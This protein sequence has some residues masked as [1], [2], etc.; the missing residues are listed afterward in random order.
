MNEIEER[1]EIVI[2][3]Q[4]VRLGWPDKVKMEAIN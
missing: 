3:F 1:G 4:V 2:R